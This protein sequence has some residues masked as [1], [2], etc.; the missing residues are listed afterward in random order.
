MNPLLIPKLLKYRMDFR[1][2]HPDYFDPDGLVI[3]IGGQGTGKT[4]SAVNYV[5][6]LLEAYPE[7]KIVTNVALTDYPIVTF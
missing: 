6:R 3:F 2:E 4:L 1:R 5:Y 7:S